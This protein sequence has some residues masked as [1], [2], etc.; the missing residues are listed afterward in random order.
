MKALKFNSISEFKTSKITTMPISS[1]YEITQEMI[2]DFAKA[3]ND[4]QWIHTDTEKAAKFSPFKKTIA[5]GFL[6]VSM[7]S[8]MIDEVITIKSI[9]T[10]FNYGLN[11]VRFPSPVPVDSKIR[12]HSSII[13][14]EDYP[15]GIKVT[16]NCKIEIENTKKPA[17]IAEFIILLFE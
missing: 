13:Q 17:C 6:S 4:Y 11:K 3:T 16:F 15:K 12:L 5:H 8:K 7:L 1:W 9:K 2:N 10:G 14:V